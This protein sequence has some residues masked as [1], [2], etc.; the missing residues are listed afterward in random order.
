ME[1]LAAFAAQ[2]GAAITGTRVQHDLPELLAAAM[3]EVAPEMTDDQVR[4][5]VSHATTALDTDANAPFWALVDQVGRLRE[6]GE[7]ELDLVTDILGVVE[8][9]QSHRGRFGRR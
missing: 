5:L 9:H 3:R 4:Q 1:L 8:T 7:E 6:L 2:A